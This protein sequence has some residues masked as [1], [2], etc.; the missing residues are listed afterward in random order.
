M[1]I[2]L[3][4]YS[5]VRV[6]ELSRPIAPIGYRPQSDDTSIATDQ[7][8]FALLRQRSPQQ[9]LQSAAALIRSARQFS[10]RCFQQRFS[11][12]SES[13]FARKVAEAWLQE[14]CPVHYQPSGSPM[15]WIQDSIQLSAQLHPI[16]E[17]LNIPY[18]VTGGVAAI[19]YGESRTTQDL[20]VVIS[21]QS[22]DVQRLAVAL[23]RLGFYVPSVDDAIA[24]G[25]LQVTEIA[26]ISRADLI[27]INLDAAELNEYEQIKFDRRQ[28]YSLQD[29]LQIYLASPEDVVISKLLWGRS[30]QSQK[31]WRDVLGVLKTQ[32][33]LLDFEYIY[34]WG[35]RLDSVDLDRAELDLASLVQRACG[36]AGVTAI[37]AQQWVAKVAPWF[38][39]AF[40]LA[41]SRGRVVRSSETI[42]RA[43]GRLYELL[44]D[45]GADRLSV[46]SRLDD[47]EIA[48][49]DRQGQ[50]M[51]AN[52]VVADRLNWRTIARQL[53]MPTT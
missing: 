3:I 29:D 14:S 31:Q 17:S 36:E 34:D 2:Q 13:Q 23:E 39:A 44:L 43:E 28:S 32:Q 12:L 38:W 15:T 35:M 22:G 40:A 52:P 33:E 48:W 26:T 47:R 53:D 19:A 45:S 11:H 42:E 18:Y 1:S 37:A 16:F 24:T 21:V 25:M 9:R 30:S 7:M 46:R 10:I 8:T 5:R 49:V 6:P 51:D 27:V 41:R 20:D 4:P 50:A